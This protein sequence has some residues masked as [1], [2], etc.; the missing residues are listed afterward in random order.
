M[1]QN[2]L[3]RSQHMKTIPPSKE[4]PFSLMGKHQGNTNIYPGPRQFTSTTCRAGSSGSVSLRSANSVRNQQLSCKPSLVSGEALVGLITWE[5][6]PWTQSWF[7]PQIPALEDTLLGTS[8]TTFSG[9]FSLFKTSFW[10]FGLFFFFKKRALF[11][12]EFLLQL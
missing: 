11:H 2:R 5:P 1:I 6:E 8:F 3:V 7:K 12:L 4:S 10:F 9:S